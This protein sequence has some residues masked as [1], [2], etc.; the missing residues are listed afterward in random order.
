[1]S[2]LYIKRKVILEVMES[3]KGTNKIQFLHQFKSLKYN[4]IFFCFSQITLGN[5][6]ELVRRPTMEPA[7]QAFIQYIPSSREFQVQDFNTVLRTGSYYWSLPY[8]YLS[9]RVSRSYYWS[10]PYQYLSKRVSR[11]NGN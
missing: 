2:L 9:K 8:Q 1:M 6:V 5:R 3:G 4:F 10:L 11:T 7:E